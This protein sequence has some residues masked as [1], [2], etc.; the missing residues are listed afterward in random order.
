MDEQQRKLKL[1]AERNRKADRA[2]D[3]ELTAARKGHLS[4]VVAVRSA[5]AAYDAVI[6][7]YRPRIWP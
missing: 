2:W 5:A 4:Y 3:R 7:A 6:A 1:L